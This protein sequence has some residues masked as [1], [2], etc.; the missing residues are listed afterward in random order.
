MIILITGASHT[1]K[2][3]LAQRLLERYQIPYVSIDHLKMGLIRSGQTNLTPEDDEEL[4]LY[5]WPIVR[6]IIKTAIENQQHLILEGCYIPFGW[7]KDF[8]EEYLK[9]ITYICLIMTEQYIREHFTDIQFYASEIEQRL[10]DPGCTIEWLLRENLYNLEMSKKYSLPYHL[11][12]KDYNT[13]I[14]CLLQHS[15][16]EC[17]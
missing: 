5:L 11:I 13:D 1:G 14:S 8:E 2:T 12:D 10:D 4:V 7:K 16:S 9:E 17:F 15:F 6:E 3:V